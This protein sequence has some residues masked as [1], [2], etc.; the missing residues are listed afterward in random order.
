MA[1]NALSAEAA[2]PGLQGLVLNGLSARE[3]EGWPVSRHA[4]G[5]RGM[6]GGGTPPSLETSFSQT[7]VGG[8]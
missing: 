2:G 5:L 3:K 4:A 1:V 6:D 7:H 8:V